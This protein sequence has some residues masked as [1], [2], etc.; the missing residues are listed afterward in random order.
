MVII[1]IPL[2]RG[3]GCSETSSDL[4]KD[5]EGK[6]TVRRSKLSVLPAEMGF[7]PQQPQVVGCR[8]LCFADLS[9]SV[10]SYKQARCMELL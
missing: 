6:R 7:L 3:A 1:D 5:I 4:L 8:E 10:K 9:L 2:H